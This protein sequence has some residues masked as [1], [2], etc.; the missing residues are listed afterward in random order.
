M[1]ARRGAGIIPPLVFELAAVILLASPEMAW[2]ETTWSSERACVRAESI[3]ARVEALLGT[4]RVPPATTLG[5]TATQSGDAWTVALDLQA[6]ELSRQR[7]LRGDD[8][9][10]LTEAVALVVAVQL[11]PVAVAAVVEPVVAPAIVPEP[12]V[13]PEPASESR[14]PDVAPR[15][16][17]LPLPRSRPRA[18]LG[19][20]I[21]G[22]IGISPRSAAAFALD[23]GV[24][25]KHVRLELGGLTSLGPDARPVDGVSSRFR[26]FAG[27]VR[28]C[29]VI[30]RDAIEF[31]ICGALEIGELWARA[32]GLDDP[33]TVHAFWLAPVI[34]IRPRWN[35]TRR[36]ALGVL[37]DV[38]IPIYRHE[39]AAPPT[40]FEHAVAPVAG[41]VGVGAEIRLP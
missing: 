5:L 9:E 17:P 8:C 22:E 38:V 10:V 21:G 18:V 27:V 41:R 30:V 19:A 29:G 14:E 12:D 34:G 2:L 11:D 31:P 16:P 36:V 25:W 13:V 15:P 23:V 32:R 35:A 39:F 28:G 37:I 6:G 24:T 3:A 33:R 1:R 20:S 26:L 7:E 4:D 40:R